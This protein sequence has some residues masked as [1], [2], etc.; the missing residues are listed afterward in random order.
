MDVGVFR[1]DHGP[2]WLGGVFSRTLPFFY[3]ML[4]VTVSVV[5]MVG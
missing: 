1:G 5:I 2:T 4:A 3:G